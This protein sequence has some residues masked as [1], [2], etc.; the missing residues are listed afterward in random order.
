MLIIQNTLNNPDCPNED[1]FIK[2]VD[3]ILTHLKQ[4]T[5]IN[6]DQY[7]AELL[8]R[9]NDTT[10][11]QNLNKQYRQKDKPTN[12]LSFPAQDLSHLPLELKAEIASQL[13]ELIICLE[14]VQIEAKLAEKTPKEHL[15]HLLIHGI[16]HL[17][18]Y[19]HIQ[20]EKRTEMEALEDELLAKFD[21]FITRLSTE[22]L[23]LSV[24]KK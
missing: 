15:T 5:L 19:D 11:S 14:V 13:G 23:S 9:L 21:I 17:L 6:E 3:K 12:I 4:D 20:A 22:K 7:N 18:G 16:L 1:W 10:E 8:I 2:T 24:N